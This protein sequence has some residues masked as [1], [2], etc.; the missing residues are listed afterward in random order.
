MDD[1]LKEKVIRR[2]K[3]TK[4]LERPIPFKGGRPERP[5]GQDGFIKKRDIVDLI[6]L[7]NTAKSFEEFLE[8][9]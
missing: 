7:L 6:I 1:D 3:L 9:C 5:V 2:I 8:L 4:A